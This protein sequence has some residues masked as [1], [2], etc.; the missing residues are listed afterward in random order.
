MLNLRKNRHFHSTQRKQIVG[1]RSP[2]PNIFLF[3]TGAIVDGCQQ[4]VVGCQLNA[5]LM[6]DV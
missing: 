6:A 5:Y 3:Q 2:R 4:S 1:A